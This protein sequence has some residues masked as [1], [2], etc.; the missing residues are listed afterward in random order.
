M[1]RRMLNVWRTTGRVWLLLVAAALGLDFTQTAKADFV[2][3]VQALNPRAYWRFETNTSNLAHNDGTGGAANDGTFGSSVTLAAGPS[4][5]GLSGNAA[6]FPGGSDAN[7]QITAPDTGFPT[8]SSARTFVGWLRTSDPTIADWREAFGYG[9]Q[10][11][12]NQNCLVA[13]NNG[14]A[15]FSQWGDSLNGTR[16]LNDG[17]WHFVALTIDTSSRCNLYFDGELEAWK[18]MTV[19]TVLESVRIGTFPNIKSWAGDIDE[20]ALFTNVLSAVTIQSLYAAAVGRPLTIV[21]AKIPWFDSTLGNPCTDAKGA[22]W[23]ARSSN[24]GGVGWWRPDAGTSFIAASSP[25]ENRFRPSA[26]N[27]GNSNRCSTPSAPEV[28]ML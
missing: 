10:N 13:L 22:V 17:L 2:S 5:P 28:S 19:N 20:V 15:A 16:S 11:T 21:W 26:C 24:P 23:S 1:N 14:Q 18:T 3:A 6:H 8:G 25:A 27:P 4:L 12:V 7:S 9:K